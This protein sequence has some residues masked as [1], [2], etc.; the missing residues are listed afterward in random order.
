MFDLTAA[1]LALQP[2]FLRRRRGLCPFSD[3]GPLGCL[4]DQ[5]HQ[6][7]NGVSAVL[8]LGEEPPGID[9]KKTFLGH[10]LSGQTGKS[11][12]NV[13]GK[14]GGMGH[15]EAKLHGRGDLIDILPA[16]PPW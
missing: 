3:L 15:I 7:G 13:L 14:G 5:I 4:A 12:P 8:F 1:M 11:F 9:D 10:T 2:P 16:R 6:T